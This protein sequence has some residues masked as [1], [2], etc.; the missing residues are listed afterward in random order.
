MI[1]RCGSGEGW[2]IGKFSPA[3]EYFNFCIEH[4][5]NIDK[6]INDIIEIAI[7]FDEDEHAR[8]WANAREMGQPQTLKELVEDAEAIHKMLIE[9]SNN[10]KN[11]K[12]K[13]W[14]NENKKNK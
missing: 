2:E 10:I 13:R 7:Y 11:K 4:N 14:K 1:I 12:V 5:N 8:L 3:G 9:L 6:M